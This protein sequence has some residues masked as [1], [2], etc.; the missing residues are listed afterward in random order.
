M[1]VPV[2]FVFS[3]R[4]SAGLAH[5]RVGA[6]GGEETEPGS[7]GRGGPRVVLE[8]AGSAEGQRGSGDREVLCGRVAQVFASGAR[9]LVARRSEGGSCSV[10][11]GTVVAAESCPRGGVGPGRVRGLPEAGGISVSPGIA[12]RGLPSA[13]KGLP[14][15]REGHEIG[16]EIQPGEASVLFG[17]LPCSPGNGRVV[18]L[19]K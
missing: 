10:A 12:S 14:S 1:F 9:G 16:R 15:E 2:Q 6:V 17:A 11:D 19:C 13:G 3:G 5:W 18:F 4:P 8:T 7:P